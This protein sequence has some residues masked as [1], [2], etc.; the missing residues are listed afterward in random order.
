MSAGLVEGVERMEE[1]F[2][3]S[4]SFGEVM[5][6]VNNKQIDVSEA[7]SELCHLS[8]LDCFVEAGHESVAGCV[9]EFECWDIAHGFLADGLQQVCLAESDSA[10]DE[11]RVVGFAGSGSDGDCGGMR[12]LVIRSDDEVRERVV[13]A[14]EH[15]LSWF[16]G[17]RG[18]RDAR[19]ARVAIFGNGFIGFSFADEVNSEQVAADVLD[20]IGEFLGAAAPE[21]FQLDLFPH[22]QFERSPTHAQRFNVVKPMPAYAWMMQ[23]QIRKHVCPDVRIGS[24]HRD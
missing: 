22:E 3:R 5:N 23:P 11:E 19:G 20:G 17:F 1:F 9:E 10:M 18:V 13:G 8:G 12:E 21:V 7:V 16:G 14:E 15:F 24:I 2:L 4:I 6:I